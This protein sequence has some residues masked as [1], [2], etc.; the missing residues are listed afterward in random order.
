MILYWIEYGISIVILVQPKMY[1]ER[2]G[3]GRERNGNRTERETVRER[4]NYS[5]IDE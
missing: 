3:N 1:R 4:K 5:N 2:N